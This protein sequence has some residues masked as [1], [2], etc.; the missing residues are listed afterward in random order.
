MV[1]MSVLTMVFLAMAF[2][3]SATAKQARSLYGDAR[4]LHRAELVLQRIRFMLYMGQVGSA[5]VKDDGRT[6]E[7]VNP[8]L[9]GLTSAFKFLSGKVY[10]YA[11][12]TA[13]ASTPGQ[14]IGLIHD[15]EFEILGAGNAVR[16]TVTTL[17]KYSWK[18]DRPFTL[19]TEV[20]LRN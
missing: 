13:A 8:N 1:A 6:L 2:L 15:L 12:K 14:G 18:L 17:Q 10:Y 4:T 5:V 7:F 19:D 9:G 11:D 3:Q 20:T 16:V